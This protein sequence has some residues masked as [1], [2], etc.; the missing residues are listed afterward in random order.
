MLDSVS[1]DKQRQ[2]EELQEA[3]LSCPS[4]EDPRVI[5][6]IAHKL[7]VRGIFGREIREDIRRVVKNCADSLGAMIPFLDELRKK[8]SVGAYSKDFWNI[9]EKW[10]SYP[11]LYAEQKQFVEW[12]QGFF[13]ELSP[14]QQG[15]A[16]AYTY[17][18][19][20]NDKSKLEKSEYPPEVHLFISLKFEN[21]IPIVNILAFSEGRKVILPES[22][23]SKSS[24]YL[25]LSKDNLSGVEQVLIIDTI[26]FIQKVLY[27]HYR[28]PSRLDLILSTEYMYKFFPEKWPTDPL[29][30]KNKLG[31]NAEVV[32]RCYD[33][34]FVS[35]LEKYDE[36]RIRYINRRKQLWIDSCSDK[37]EKTDKISDEYDIVICHK[38]SN[39]IECVDRYLQEFPYAI[40]S[41]QDIDRE[42]NACK[43]LHEI[44]DD[45]LDK[46]L[47]NQLLK[48]RN[49]HYA[50]SS[51]PI[52][53]IFLVWDDASYYV[54]IAKVIFS[55]LKYHEEKIGESSNVK[56]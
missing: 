56:Q 48:L 53:S 6:E 41:R 23:L 50:D 4:L 18:E 14:V 49:E 25:N 17:D 27:S 9:I 34:F 52:N 46:D 36:I 45:K 5:Q 31:H 33:N 44:F 20:A 12:I 47:P 15:I 28:F 10:R 24:L 11:K 42:T 37:S 7:K 30:R 54:E 26:S 1:S 8:E 19:A 43:C 21:E 35:H 40:V 38:T 3:V 13:D 51:H 55:Q 22:S 32:F 16:K 29:G 2:L 39:D